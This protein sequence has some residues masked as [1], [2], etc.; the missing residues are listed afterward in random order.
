MDRKSAEEIL[1]KI[2]L[3]GFKAYFVGGC[4]RDTI[5]D[6]PVHDWD[7]VTSAKPEDIH[8]IFTKFTDINSERFGIT[9][10]NEGGENVEIATMRKDGTSSDGRRPDSVEY[11]DDIV[12]DAKRRDF[13]MNA[14]Y[15]DAHGVIQDP[16][17]L[18][19]D[20]LE[21][22][23]IRFVGSPKDRINED[24]LRL[25]RMFRFFATKHNMDGGMFDLD[26]S[27]LVDRTIDRSLSGVSPERIGQE[28][29]KLLGGDYAAEAIEAMAQDGIINSIVP[30]WQDMED[31][32]QNPKWHKE[33]DVSKH[34]ILVCE[35]MEKQEHDWIDMAASLL[36]DI[37][38][39]EAAKRNGKK[40]PEDS[41]SSQHGHETIGAVELFPKIVSAWRLTSEE[42][43]TIRY[44]IANHM[45]VHNIKKEPVWAQWKM[46]SNPL[47]PRLVKLCRADSD[48]C[49]SDLKDEFE[50]YKVLD[51]PL[52]KRFMSE[53]LPAP[54]IRGA[55]LSAKGFAPCRMF[56]EALDKAFNKQLKWMSEGK[57]VDKDGTMYRRL[58]N[59][60]CD[61]LKNHKE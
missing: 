43:G 16:T 3:S 14:L 54:L 37:S 18:G 5:L 25:L 41:W 45:S 47:V 29:R 58:L 36:H 17:G 32:A 22:G 55:D 38:K 24:K 2:T 19:T 39:P 12:E 51:D 8:K 53:P 57:T 48:G 27:V 33:G 6:T 9:V 60:A 20:D 26:A 31:C 21:R 10:I 23:L 61:V 49:V 1:N 7:I 40:N 56:G 28:M 52:I 30:M 46:L 35:A 4:V 13:T 44:L 42:A 59:E 50:L 34:T 11:V 15:M